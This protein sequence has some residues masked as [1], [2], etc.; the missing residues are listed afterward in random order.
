MV[1]DLSVIYKSTYKHFKYYFYGVVSDK[2]YLLQLNIIFSEYIRN[3][4]INL[5]RKMIHKQLMK[6]Y[7]KPAFL[8]KN[9]KYKPNIYCNFL[10][11]VCIV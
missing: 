8:H 3:D 5:C 4:M 2:Q 9:S 6:P 11:A 10:E 7:L 1:T